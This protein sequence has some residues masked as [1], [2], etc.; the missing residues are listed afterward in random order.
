MEVVSSKT[1]EYLV[2]HETLE[3]KNITNLDGETKIVP[4]TGGDTGKAEQKYG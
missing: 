1:L 4:G 3:P 2:T